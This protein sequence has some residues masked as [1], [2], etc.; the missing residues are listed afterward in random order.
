[1]FSF[2]RPCGH[3]S[4]FTTGNLPLPNL[5]NGV[6]QKC[7]WSFFKHRIVI[8][9]SEHLD[10]VVC[11]LSH[12]PLSRNW[13]ST[14][15]AYSMV[16]VS[17]PVTPDSLDLKACPT[18]DLLATCDCTKSKIATHMAQHRIKYLPVTS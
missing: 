4:P 6:V 1:M 13:K 18:W 12:L 3:C 2:G 17:D 15:T 5:G 9:D 7:Y 16:T 8:V 11:I 14:N 10:F